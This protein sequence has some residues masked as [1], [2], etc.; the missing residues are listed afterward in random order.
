MNAAASTILVVRRLSNLICASSQS[1]NAFGV[2]TCRSVP[3]LGPPVDLCFRSCFPFA[4]I[5]ASLAAA[6]AGTATCECSDSQL[7][8]G[9]LPPNPLAEGVPSKMVDRFVDVTLSDKSVNI[10]AIPDVI[11]REIYISTVNLT[12]NAVYRSLSQLHGME[13]VGHRIVLRRVDHVDHF[14]TDAISA[15]YAESS[16]TVD[17]AA[18]EAVADRLL[19][20]SAINQTLVPDVVE[21]QLYLNCLKLAFSLLS[22]V[23]RTLRVS[24]CNH[25]LVARF[26]PCAKENCQQMLKERISERAEKNSATLTKV[27]L[28]AVEAFARE[29]GTGLFSEQRTLLQRATVPGE[30]QLIIQLHKTLYALILSVIDDLLQDT[31]LTFLTDSFQL[32]I[33]PCNRTDAGGSRI[34]IGSD[35]A[36][37]R[38]RDI[39][40][41]IPAPLYAS[42]SNYP[43]LATPAAAFLVGAVVGAAIVRA[44][45]ST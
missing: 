17:H 18:L 23:F 32:D 25:N 3:I 2:S 43:G 6:S 9:E 40:P 30:R 19:Q 36:V 33:E 34:R 31:V 42:P 39:R 4:A 29:S 12:L 11:E 37:D 8:F 16:G 21:R 26:E 14:A 1:R 10:A 44:M 35:R 13:V 7:G 27:D 24:V 38:T 45:K 5:L 28:E 20:N 41:D 15:T 22:T